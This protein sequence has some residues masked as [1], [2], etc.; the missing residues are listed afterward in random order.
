LVDNHG[1]VAPFPA[2]AAAHRGKTLE[3][4]AL[5]R[6]FRCGNMPV[7]NVVAIAYSNG[8]Q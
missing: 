7:I 5:I 8:L 1:P 2:A 4:R 6:C 3:I